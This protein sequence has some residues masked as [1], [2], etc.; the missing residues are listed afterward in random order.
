MP[1]NWGSMRFTPK[2]KA[3]IDL[4]WKMQVAKA[5]AEGRW[6]PVWEPTTTHRQ[7]MRECFNGQN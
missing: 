1:V 6:P 3:E 4:W 7:R 2:E 5:K